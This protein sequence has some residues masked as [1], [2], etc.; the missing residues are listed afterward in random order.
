MILRRAWHRFA[1]RMGWR[2]DMVH[3]INAA[4]KGQEI[5]QD[6]PQGRRAK[7]EGFSGSP[8]TLGCRFVR[9]DGVR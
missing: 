9:W 1:V 7:L 5:V 8:V 6:Y 2:F 3:E 4:T